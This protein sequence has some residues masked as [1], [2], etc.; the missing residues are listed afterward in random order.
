MKA[1]AGRS[2]SFRC[3]EIPFGRYYAEILRNEGLNEFTVTDISLV[4]PASGWYDVVLLA[5]LSRALDFR[6]SD[7]ADRLGDGGW[8]SDRHAA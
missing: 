2:W 6:R 4:T 1:P 5:E 7:D 8:Q 3:R